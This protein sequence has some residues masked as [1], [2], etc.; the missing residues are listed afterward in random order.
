MKKLYLILLISVLYSKGLYS[1][2]NLIPNGGFED[3]SD[4]GA[5]FSDDNPTIPCRWGAFDEFKKYVKNNKHLPGIPSQEEVEKA[6][7]IEVGEFQ[8]KLLEKLEEMSLY[9]FELNEKITKLEKENEEINKENEKLE[10]KIISLE[11]K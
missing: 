11:K 7:G 2:E 10:S 8:V 1:Q 6:G 3:R 4:P 5:L 9:L